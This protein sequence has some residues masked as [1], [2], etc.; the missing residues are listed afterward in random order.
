MDELDKILEKFDALYKDTLISAKKKDENINKSVSR[1]RT[2]ISLLSEQQDISISD[3][4]KQACYEKSLMHLNLLEDFFSLYI[5]ENET[6]QHLTYAFL[7]VIKLSSNDQAYQR[8]HSYFTK[9]NNKISKKEMFLSKKWKN[10][11]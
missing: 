2:L 1:L 5:E 8:I 3:E 11:K 4:E 6:N 10:E 9:Y 7:S